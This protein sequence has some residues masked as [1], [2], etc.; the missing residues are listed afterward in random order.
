[1][2]VQVVSG[3]NIVVRDRSANAERRF[4]LSSIRAPKLGRRDDPR[5]A[6]PYAREAREMLRQRLI[7]DN[8]RPACCCCC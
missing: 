6:E 1:M 3:D 2:G 5:S 4:F 7:G 8:C